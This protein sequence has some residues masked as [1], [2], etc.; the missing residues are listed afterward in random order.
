MISFEKF[1]D[2]L[3]INVHANVVLPIAHVCRIFQSHRMQEY[4]MCGVHVM[5]TYVTC[6]GCPGHKSLAHRLQD[7]MG[8]MGSRPIRL[9]LKAQAG[10]LICIYFLSC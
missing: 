9:V 8:C 2:T 5:A 10:F 6:A 1:G 7:L 3:A 4:S